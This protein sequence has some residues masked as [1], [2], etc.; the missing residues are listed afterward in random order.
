YRDLD[1]LTDKKV[2]EVTRA[3][4]LL[5]M[6]NALQPGVFALSGCDLVSAL[7]IPAEDVGS[8]LQE[9]DMRWI[10]C[11]VYDLLGVD[12]TAERSGSTMPRACTYYGSIDGQV[13][14]P[15]SFVTRVRDVLH[16][17]EY[18]AS[19]ATRQVDVPDVTK[20]AM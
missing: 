14:Q 12:P 10:H 20:K 19:A 8:L 3:H 13:E 17:R 7:P 15:D 6:F 16:L 5:A 18:F 4:L 9:W 2:D 11:P 1:D